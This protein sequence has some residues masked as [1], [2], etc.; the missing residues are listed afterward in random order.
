MENKSF[1]PCPY[2][3]GRDNNCADCE[4]QAYRTVEELTALVEAKKEG[5]LVVLPKESIAAR[6]EVADMLEDDLKESSFYDPSVGIYGLTWAQIDL[7]RAII[8]GLNAGN[9]EAEAAPPGDGKT[10]N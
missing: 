7:W 1:S 6:F 4:L 10:K 2:C 9:A 3:D 5:R 8:D